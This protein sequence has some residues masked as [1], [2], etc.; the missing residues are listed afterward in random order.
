MHVKSEPWRLMTLMDEA[1]DG[2]LAAAHP[3]PPWTAPQVEALWDNLLNDWPLG[4]FVLLDV[5]TSRERPWRGRLGPHQVRSTAPRRLLVEEGAGKLA[6]LAW[7]LC[8]RPSV[9]LNQCDAGEIE[10]W[11][12]HTLVLDIDLRRARFVSQ[13]FTPNRHL[14]VALLPQAGPCL[15]A[16]NAMELRTAEREWANLA[17]RRLLE[18]RCPVYVFPDTS[19]KLAERMLTNIRRIAGCEDHARL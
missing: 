1:R 9:I 5:S 8:A 3:V 4:P 11:T 2:R 13:D 12:H 15:H 16:M 19:T 14:P 18:A 10:L 7:S 17:A 6:A